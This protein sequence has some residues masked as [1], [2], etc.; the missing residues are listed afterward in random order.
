MP[1]KVEIRS[2]RLHSTAVCRAVLTDSEPP[3]STIITS[4]NTMCILS[5][6]N[7]NKKTLSHGRCRSKEHTSAL[8][9]WCLSRPQSRKVQLGINKKNSNPFVAQLHFIPFSSLV[10]HSLLTDLLRHRATY[11]SVMSDI[12]TQSCRSPRQPSLMPRPLHCY[13]YFIQP[14]T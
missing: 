12:A 1:A 7:K 8:H 9:V 10:T 4:G 13:M 2:I 5:A 3:C 6:K 11:L 14:H